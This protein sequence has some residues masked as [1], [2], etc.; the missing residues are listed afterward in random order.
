MSQPAGRQDTTRARADRHPGRYGCRP[1]ACGRFNKSDT[2]APRC[3]DVRRP[4]AANLTGVPMAAAIEDYALVGDLHTAALVARDGS[5]DW[6]CLPRFDSPACFAALLHNQ[7]AG[8]WLL[9][10]AAGGPAAHRHIHIDVKKLGRIPDGG[11]HKTLGRA[12]ARTRAGPAMSSSTGPAA[13]RSQSSSYSA[14]TAGPRKAGKRR[15]RPLRASRRGALVRR[16]GWPGQAVVVDQVQHTRGR[17]TRVGGRV[18]PEALDRCRH[19]RGS[20]SS[21]TRRPLWIGRSRRRRWH[22]RAARSR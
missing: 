10:P 17:Q 9:A 8:R 5:I 4:R 3:R 6:L 19:R 20:S 21:V 18:G 1:S 13:M 16:S 22:P 14:R 12:A 7:E 2:P 11:A 15:C